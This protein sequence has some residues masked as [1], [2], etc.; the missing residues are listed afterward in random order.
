MGSW[1]GARGV[2]H[3]P[4]KST[5]PSCPAALHGRSLALCLDK[6]LKLI[7]NDIGWPAVSACFFSQSLAVVHK[8]LTDD[9]PSQTQGRHRYIFAYPEAAHVR[10]S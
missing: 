6:G 9:M 2:S 8:L 7:Q 1:Y 10:W 3:F 5:A 4:I